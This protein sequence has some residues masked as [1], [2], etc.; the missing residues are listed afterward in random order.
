M[1]ERQPLPDILKGIAVFLMIQ[2]HLTEIFGKAEFMHSI[3]GKASLFLGGLPAAP[4]F[5]FIMGFFIYSQKPFGKNLI[6]GL[7]LI[8]LGIILN[9]GLNLNL[10]IRIANGSIEGSFFSWIFGVD[11]LFLAGL[12]IIILAI[13]KTIF[14]NKWWFYLLLAIIVSILSTVIPDLSSG[15]SSDYI[16]AFVCGKGIWWSYFPLLPWLAYPFAGYAL[17]AFRKAN[18]DL[19]DKISTHLYLKITTA[20]IFLGAL[21]YGWEISTDLQAYYHHGTLFFIWALSGMYWW[22]QLWAYLLKIIPETQQLQKYGRNV[23]LLYIVQW[24]LIGNIGTAVYQ[25]QSW[26]FLIIWFLLI[27]YVSIKITNLGMILQKKLA[28]L[29]S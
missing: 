7:K 1:H 16:L 6:R 13:L 22:Y 20:L 24:L 12:S 14:K 9:T 18:P 5:M 28:A 3:A 11:I 10:L 15:K 21:V 25:T 8:F 23:T 29:F 19:F 4:V 27:T 26:Q 17:N 2:V